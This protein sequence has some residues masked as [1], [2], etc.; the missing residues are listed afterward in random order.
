M[1]WQPRYWRKTVPAWTCLKQ[2]YGNPVLLVPEPKTFDEAYPYLEDWRNLGRIESIQTIARFRAHNEKEAFD[3]A[4]ELVQ[5]GQRAENSGGPIIHYL[6][7]S[8]IETLGLLRVQQMT[9]QTILPESDLMG[10]IR[11]LDRFGPNREGLTNALKVEYQLDSRLLDDYAKGKITN[12]DSNSD[13]TVMAV[14][15]KPLFSASKT[16]MKFAQSI[17]VIR[18]GI[19][20]PYGEIP[21]SDLPEM[22]TN[23]SL[24]KRLIKGNMVG[25]VLFEMMEP[26]FKSLAV[27]KSREEVNVTATQLLL[28]LRIYQMRHG[29]LPESLS[30][31]VPE[32][33]PSVP[34]DDFD[35]KT[36]RY[37]PG[38]KLIYS[39]GPDL[40]DSGGVGF[41]KD[42]KDF[43]LPFPIGF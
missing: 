6:V 12:A 35:G 30:E 21:W 11:E 1:H 8:S 14:G 16:K 26:S 32:F 25:D 4:M 10:L 5:F 33:F 2:Q 42:S 3:S 37:L 24:F 15:I 28:A 13:Q 40:K 17:R 27:R 39:V 22:P 9:A 23:H 41:R 43:D 18:V 36:F 29:Q 31:L 7:G 20:K 38:Q 34:L 19:S